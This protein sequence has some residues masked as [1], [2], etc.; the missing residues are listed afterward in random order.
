MD[1]CLDREILNLLKVCG[2]CINWNC[3][4]YQHYCK[5]TGKVVARKRFETC[6]KWKNG[7]ETPS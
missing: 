1:E 3:E 2:N 4:G 5:S 6:D 7:K